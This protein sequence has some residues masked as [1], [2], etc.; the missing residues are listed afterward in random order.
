MSIFKPSNKKMRTKGFYGG[1][2]A[3]KSVSKTMGAKTLAKR[4]LPVVGAAIGANELRKNV[5]KIV[6]G[7]KALGKNWGYIRKS[8]KKTKE[9][10]AKFVSD[11]AK[12]RYKDKHGQ[13]DYNKSQDKDATLNPDRSAYNKS[14]RDINKKY[15]Y[16]D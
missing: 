2:K 12:R 11:R 7:V 4:A 13:V 8:K 16:L 14:K 10:K 5:P 1:K 9:M 6:K 15:G 3:L